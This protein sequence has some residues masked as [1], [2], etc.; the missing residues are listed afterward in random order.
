M[1]APSLALVS[2]QLIDGDPIA[3]AP[4]FA[5]LDI[6]DVPDLLTPATIITTLA[7]AARIEAFGAD[8]DEEVQVEVS[9]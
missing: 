1:I 6:C 3:L 8:E 7:D 4:Q 2:V 5:A 9:H